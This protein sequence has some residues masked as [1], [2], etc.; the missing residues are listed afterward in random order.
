MTKTLP[1]TFTIQ[2]DFPPVDYD[3]WR[4][5]VDK[6]LGGAPFERKLV[7]RSYDGIEIQPLYSDRDQL[8]ADPS[9][10][11]GF[12]P[13][14]RGSYPLAAATCGWDLRQE[15]ADPDPAQCNRSILNDLNAGVTSLQLR[16]DAAVRD[17]LDADHPDASAVAGRGGLMAYR[18]EDLDAIL[19]DVRLDQV[20][21][22]LDAGAAFLPA[23]AM[24]IGLCRQRG[25]ADG[26]ISAAFNADPL[27][28]LAREGRLP[29]PAG[30]ALSWLADLSKWT[31]AQCPRATSVGVDTSPYHD[32][33]ATPAQDI[34]LAVATA[35]EYLRAMADH[36]ID[37]DTAARQIL[38]R[39]GLGTHHFHA[40]AKLR[41]ARAVWSRVV[42]ASG[43][44]A[45]AQR[46]KI[47]ARTA[48]RVLTQHDPHVN[49]LRNAV[50]VFAAGVAGAETITSLPFD[51]AIGLPSDLSRRVARNTVH[52]LQ[53]ESHL[54]RVV[55][56]AG[57]SWY[58]ER[59]TDDVAKKAW[60]I[61]QQ[62]ERQGGMLA[63]LR[64]GWV[65]EQIE[66]AFQPRAKDIARRKAGITGVSEF[67]DIEQQPVPVA[68]PDRQRLAQQASGRLAGHKPELDAGVIEAA[69]DKTS[70]VVQA[71]SRGATIG[72]I[73]DALGFRGG[74]SESMD[75]LRPRRL[76]EP[77]ERLRDASAA[78]Q[79]EHG[80]RPRVML[81]NF[82]P[83]AHHSARAG[84]SKNFFEAGGFEVTGNEPLADADAAAAALKDSGATIAVICSSDKLYPDVV[85]QAAARLRQAGAR[86]IVL[87]GHPGE[88]ESAWREAGVDRFIFISC[89][90]LQT[91]RELLRDQGVIKDQE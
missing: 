10:L 39:F 75:P 48:N 37:V 23:A 80:H 63:A 18:V 59:L 78:W 77:F 76:A 41:A 30:T 13:F 65:S 43:G 16:F 56:P 20:R 54:H 27:G 60:E 38:F 90:V 6:A 58:L 12:A 33:G 52:V 74:A 84:W 72:Q 9:G 36:G 8:A 89:D 35:V 25:V 32:A 14:I 85:P 73:A 40:I 7:R 19:A 82:G 51:A 45:D 24:L 2:Q 69:D 11:P 55:D 26:Q 88:N 31:S 29:V 70:A 50:A 42:Q 46:M 61:F 83:L 68:S 4:A 81:A 22:G 49:L 62:I 87:A 5:I 53:E 57:G 34:A 64:C 21:V 71:V 91:L 79:A 44:S 1:E 3:D 86:T 15:F 67:P 47:H 28:T 66:T 17:G